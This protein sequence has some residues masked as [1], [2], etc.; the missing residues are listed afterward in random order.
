VRTGPG[1]PVCV[2]QA[3]VIVLNI[4][5]VHLP[6]P[7]QPTALTCTLN[8]GIHFVT[9][10]ECELGPECR[11]DQ[12]FEL[13]AESLPYQVFNNNSTGLNTAN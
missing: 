13:Y 1:E 4:K 11:I 12:E 5:G 6:L 9:T 3:F 2:A 7:Q 10:P 8:N